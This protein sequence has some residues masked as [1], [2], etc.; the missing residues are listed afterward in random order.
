MIDDTDKPVL[1]TRTRFSDLG[2]QAPI[3]QALEEA[4]YTHALEVQE[5][6][7]IPGMAGRD[8]VVRSRTGSGKTL[9]FTLPALHRIDYS[10]L[11]PQVLALAPTREL[12]LQVYGEFEKAGARVGLRP[13]AIYGGTGFR[14]QI[15]RLE[16]G[17]HA[18]VGTPGRVMDHYRRGNLRLDTVR[19]F[20][21]DEA[22]EMLSAGFYEDILK[23]FKAVKPSL[24]QTM[25]F[26]ATLDPNIERLIGRYMREPVQIDLSSDRVDVDRIENVGFKID[27]TESR[28]R[29]L[30][31]L[32]ES[33]DPGCAIIFC[34]TRSNT[35][36]VTAYLRRRGF[37][38]A[39]LNSDLSQSAREAVMGRMKAGNQRLLVA[40][41][42]AARGIDISFLPCV[43]N[44]EPPFDA[45]LY[46]HRTGRTG[47][48]D[49]RGRALTLIAHD[50][51]HAMRRIENTYNL[52]LTMRELPTR[53][54]TLKMLSDRRIREFKERLDAGPVIPD[55]FRT[56]AREILTDPDA[57]ALVAL[58]V[59]RYLATLVNP[60]DSQAAAATRHEDGGDG[61]GRR[62]RSGGGGGGGGG[63]RGPRR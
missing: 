25:L 10:R 8:L 37:D 44:Y 62:R 34:N 1:P 28:P 11:E 23:V 53:E 47:R 24:E 42:I 7:T 22:D 41:D 36:V 40:T 51:V 9:A 15:D 2:L 48:V 49:R 38:A 59:D 3:V 30:V 61:G 56:M 60:N 35:E 20:V 21:L 29:A 27:P 58:F 16:A 32:L 33:E 12:A 17:V 57:E 39:I 63:G 31:S 4:G 45:E 55:E 43:I 46:I 54:E 52:K 6:C 5:A 13:V 18:I 14:T 50:D 26:S 19:I